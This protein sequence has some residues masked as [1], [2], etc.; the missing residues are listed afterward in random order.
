MNLSNYDTMYNNFSKDVKQIASRM[1]E[2]AGS[3]I[4]RVAKTAG[5]EG[6]QA[7]FDA[8][9]DSGNREVL[10]KALNSPSLP[11]WVREQLEVFLYGS[12]KQIPALFQAAYRRDLH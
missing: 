2:E 11:G 1:A 8:V 10:V 7:L 4:N 12:Q 6:A 3:T 5:Q 9:M